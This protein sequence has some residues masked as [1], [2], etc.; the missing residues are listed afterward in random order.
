MHISR[1][2]GRARGTCFFFVY[3]PFSFHRLSEGGREG[4][5]ASLTFSGDIF[6]HH[7][8]WTGARA[9]DLFSLRLGPFRFSGAGGG[10]L[11]FWRLLALSGGAARDVFLVLR[12]RHF[13]THGLDGWGIL[14]RL[15]I[16]CSSTFGMSAWG[17]LLFCASAVSFSRT[18]CARCLFLIESTWTLGVV[19]YRIAV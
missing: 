10:G 6:S 11:W 15:S 13:S 1:S 5:P 2:G 3:L 7:A 8:S 18:H 9:H 12:F 4:M 14:R 19:P 17:I 16:L